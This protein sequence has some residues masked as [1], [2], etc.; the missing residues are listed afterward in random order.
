ML[1][2]VEILKTVEQESSSARSVQSYIL[3]I[4]NTLPSSGALL[5]NFFNAEPQRANGDV[6]PS[7]EAKTRLQRSCYI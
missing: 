3:Q 1:H 2:P 7:H 4:A 6:S 5:I